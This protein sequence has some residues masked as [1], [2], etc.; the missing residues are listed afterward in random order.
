MI[1]FIYKNVILSVNLQGTCAPILLFR[2]KTNF[3]SE[4]PLGHIK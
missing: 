3:P 4:E 2:V 1:F